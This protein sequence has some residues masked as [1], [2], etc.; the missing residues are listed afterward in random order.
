MPTPV[1]S[2]ITVVY[3]GAAL[4]PGT[5]ESVRGQTYSNLEYLIVDGGSSDGTVD[6]IRQYAAEMPNLRWVSE[7]DR[8]LYDAMNK[9]LRLASGDFVW[10]MNC[11]DHV[12]EPNTVEKIANLIDGETDV[13]FGET[14]L[15][16]EARQAVGTMS[17]LSTRSVPV[18][19]QWRDYMRGMLVVHQSFIARR[20]LAPE[21]IPDNLCADYDWCIRILKKSRKNVYAGGIIS[22]YLMG[23]M[24]KQ[25]H[26]Q[27][28]KD[29]FSVMHTH[30]GLARTLLAHGYIVLRAFSHRI[31]RMGDTRY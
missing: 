23:G 16:N 1:F 31:R 3:N 14:L 8:G 17:D 9:G 22:D 11:G 20:A 28:L 21:Y 26:W 18:R 7:K 6:L 15:V 25:R 2:I 5:V 13:V 12:H 29:R 27:S 24:S 30:Y 4:L 10:F 19:L